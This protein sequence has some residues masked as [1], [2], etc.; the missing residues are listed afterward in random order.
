MC[1][2]DLSRAEL[3]GQIEAGRTRRHLAHAAI[4]ECQTNRSHTKKYRRLRI[5]VEPNRMNHDRN[6]RSQLEEK[7]EAYQDD[8]R[9]EGEPEY[10]TFWHDLTAS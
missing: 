7:A 1:S 10:G 9:Q 2:S 8:K 3:F 6:L 5:G 4:G